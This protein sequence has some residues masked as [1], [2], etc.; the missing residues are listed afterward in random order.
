VYLI[1]GAHQLQP[2][3]TRRT[4]ARP[5]VAVRC[6]GIRDR[7][8]ATLQ[9]R[10]RRHDR[11]QISVAAF[12]FKG[13]NAD[14]ARRSAPFPLGRLVVMR[15][16]PACRNWGLDLDRRAA[17]I[18][19]P[20][21]KTNGETGNLRKPSWADEEADLRIRAP[22]RGREQGGHRKRSALRNTASVS[23][24][25]DVLLDALV[26]ARD[27]SSMQSRPAAPVGESAS[28]RPGQLARTRWKTT[29][30]PRNVGHGFMVPGATPD[31]RAA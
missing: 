3:M 24:V 1:P 15:G 8:S 14:E 23:S 6:H 7:G 10:E 27:C 29:R 5:P 17:E 26:R 16:D 31:R 13:L 30:G 21:A 9:R 28:N 19:S 18:T 22:S 4:D 11:Q 2:C 25:F 20:R 12:R